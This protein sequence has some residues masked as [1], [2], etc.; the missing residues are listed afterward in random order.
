[1]KKTNKGTPGWMAAV[2]ALLLIL[3]GCAGNGEITEGRVVA[4][5][6]ITVPGTTPEAADPAADAPSRHITETVNENF[7]IDADVVGYPADGIAGIY[8]GTP[9]RLTK[10][11]I[12]AFLASCGYTIASAE[13]SNDGYTD[14]YNGVCNSGNVFYYSQDSSGHPYSQLV[15]RNDAKY[16]TYQPYPIYLGE[17]DYITNSQYT[18][19]WMFTE[20][21]DLSFATAAEAEQNVRSALAALG[22]SDLKLLRTLYC[23]HQTLKA[24]MERLATH[25]DY[26]PLGD[27]QENNGYVI[28]ED[29]SEADDVYI[30]SFGIPVRE[31]SLSY[32]MFSRET[33]AYVG[34]NIYVW[35]TKDGIIN[36]NIETP[37]SVGGEEA[38]PQPLIPAEEALETA[39][40]KFSFDL[41]RQDKRI[42]EIR[43]EY[44]YF[45][46]RDRW[47]LR[48]VW[49]VFLSYTYDGDT[50][51]YNTFMDIDA[52][53]GDEL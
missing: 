22:L 33:S 23:D 26:A 6:T 44:Q 32:R 49:A 35:Y 31:I 40:V 37:W 38:L 1:M 13:E 28:K 17:R 34:S 51:R 12:A 30:F 53:T 25:E 48:P 52:I 47:L 50:S 27:P 29:W 36:A 19:G 18:V 9:K 43:L 21:K 45:Q 2:C 7:H 4:A 24:A 3:G 16:Q 42:E 41:K 5:T 8:I 20:P 39:K 10:E 15:Y 11:E 14:Y 46:D